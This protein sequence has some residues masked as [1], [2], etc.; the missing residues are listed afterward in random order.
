MRHR[1][2]RHPNRC[3]RIVLYVERNVSQSECIRILKL[4]TGSCMNMATGKPSAS[5]HSQPLAEQV[6]EAVR[7]LAQTFSLRLAFSLAVV[8][9]M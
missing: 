4:A 9:I 8:Y 7:L 1:V 3:T 6:L 5:P 2:Q